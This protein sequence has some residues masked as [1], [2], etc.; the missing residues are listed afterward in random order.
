MLWQAEFMSATANDRASDW[1]TMESAAEAE[2]VSTKT[3]RRWTHAI[4]SDP[5]HKLRKHFKPS[6][7]KVA[8]F[9]ANKKTF[10]WEFNGVALDRIVDGRNTSNRGASKPR[11]E[12][13]LAGSREVVEYL[14][15]QNADLKT[16][17][18]AEREHNR[19]MQT[20]QIKLQQAQSITQGQTNEL[21]QKLTERLQLP[22]SV[23]A[24]QPRSADLP[25]VNSGRGLD[26]VRKLLRKEIHLPFVSRI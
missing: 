19:K 4:T 10:T 11:G 22:E 16:Q 14:K 12:S 7:E 3:M 5:K 8:E 24:T 17:L 23:G 1:Y 13:P 2:S 15:S 6:P 21:L 18:A 25:T 20:E 26:R 9:K